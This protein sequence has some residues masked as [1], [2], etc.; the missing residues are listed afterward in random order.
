MMKEGNGFRFTLIVLFIIFITIYIS[1]ATGYYDYQQYKKVELTNEKI[2]QFEEDVKEGRN[3]DIGNY[4]DD[5]KHNYN[6]G[7]SQMGLRF[8]KTVSVFVRKG[9]NN[10]FKFL[11][12]LLTD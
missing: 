1:Q 5:T 7:V 8:S 12:K 2:K 3:I 9:V 4:L 11:E 6:N 10:A